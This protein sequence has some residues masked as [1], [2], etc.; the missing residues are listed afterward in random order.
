MDQQYLEFEFVLKSNGSKEEFKAEKVNKVVNWAAQGLDVSESAILMSASAKVDKLPSTEQIHDALIQAANDL[1][2]E[3]EPD[4]GKVAARLKMFRIRKKAFGEFEPDPFYGH[5]VDKTKRGLYDKHILE[6]YSKREIEFLEKYMVHERDLD[7]AYPAAVQW[8]EKYLIQNRNTKEIY[9]SPQQSLMLIAMCLHAKENPDKRIGYVLDFYDQASRNKISL[10][11]PI[12]G[13]VRSPKRQFSSCCLIESGDSL[14]SITAATSAIVKYISN[15]AGIG[16]NGG[17][18]RALG[19]DIR[20]GDT[21]HTGVIPFYKMFHSAV[22]SCSQGG[23]RGGAAT[24]FYPVWHLELENLLVLKNNRGTENNRIRGLDYGVQLSGLFYKRLV[25][26]ENITLFSPDVA[27]GEL[28]RLYFEDSAKFEE[29]YVKLENDA[30]VKQKSLPAQE[31]FLAIATERAQ[32]G[33]I[34]IQN[35]DNCTEQGVFHPELA[36]VRQSNLCLE[37]LLPTQPMGH[38]DEEIALCTLAAINL[39]LVESYEDFLKASRVLTRALDNLLDYQHYPVDA[40]L[41][42]KKRRTLGVGVVNLAY[43]L[44][45]R[46]FKYGDEGSKLYTHQTFEALQYTLLKASNELAKE[47]GKCELFHHTK[48]NEGLL[49]IDNYN[50]NVD[51]IITTPYLCDW[52]TL[53]NDIIEYGLRNSTLSALMPS[54]TS[55]QISNATNGIEPPRAVVTTKGS[56]DGLYRQIIPEAAELRYDYTYVWDMESNDGYLE[57]V[58]IMQK[59]VDQAISA[60][61]NYDPAKFPGNKVPANIILRDLITAYKNGIK[62]L[63]YH[64]TRDGGDASGN[65]EEDDCESGA[66]KI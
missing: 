41:K 60:N 27:N 54:E 4:Y 14:D 51:K 25:R 59:F 29:L 17:A 42:N 61:T 3:H 21:S 28:Y 50:R 40:A 10:P 43:A 32:T 34:Y 65:I 49:P 9:E 30:L 7:Y 48:Y 39:G 66:C 18:I 38:V 63:Y 35:V 52:D 2:T 23:I 20:G 12:M 1:A 55:S 45:K 58:A 16:I 44:A 22:K 13:G 46:G 8:A 37:I 26:N 19:A 53:H 56:K 33:R 6:D 36:P 5:I 47:R 64:N 15:R 62:T 57:L 31:V 11:T 24:L